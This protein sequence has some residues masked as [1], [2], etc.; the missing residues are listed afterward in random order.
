M[1]SK[2]DRISGSSDW[3]KRGGNVEEKDRRSTK[4]TST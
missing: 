1:E 4:L 3:S 2:R